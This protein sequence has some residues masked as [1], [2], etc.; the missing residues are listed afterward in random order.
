VE[1]NL[2]EK[3]TKHYALSAPLGQRIW[4]KVDQTGAGK[5][6]RAAPVSAAV[7]LTSLLIMQ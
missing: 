2:V 3:I 1:K 7:L 6:E 4:Q 5:K